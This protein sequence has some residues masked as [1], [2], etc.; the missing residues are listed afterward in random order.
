M[1]RSVWRFFDDYFVGLLFEDLGVA[2]V[3]AEGVEDLEVAHDGEFL[4]GL[5]PS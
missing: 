5:S 3:P 1:S 4:G 2:V